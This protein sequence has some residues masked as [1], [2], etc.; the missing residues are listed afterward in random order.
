MVDPANPSATPAVVEAG[1]T[2]GERG[3]FSGTIDANQQLTNWHTRTIIYAKGDGRLY[4]ISTLRDNSQ[5]PSQ[6]SSEAGASI[7]CDTDWRVDFSDHNQSVYL[8][9][10]AGND[11]NCLLAGDNIWKM[12]RVGMSAT[13]SPI[14]AKKVVGGIWDTNSAIIGF[15]VIEGQ[16][17]V[18]CDKNFQNCS[19]VISFANEGKRLWGSLL[20]VD[21][22]IYHYNVN[23]SSL[24]SPLHT[25]SVG[26]PT[27]VPRASDGFNLYFADGVKL[28]S[29]PLNGSK[30]STLLVTENGSI[31]TIALTTN[32]ATYIVSGSIK[33]IGKLGGG[34]ATV[35]VQN[36]AIQLTATGNH[37]Y[38][39]RLSPTV[40]S[41]GVIND[42]GAG[43]TE[44]IGSF[45]N[46]STLSSTE[47]A[48][49]FA[50]K[51]LI[52]AEGCSVNS[53]K[54][55]TLKSFDAATNSGETI[56]GTTPDDVNNIFLFGFEDQILGVGNDVG[57]NADV[58]FADVTQ[59]NSLKRIT[60][61]S[62]IDEALI[63]T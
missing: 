40:V 44:L 29:L 14:T 61:T 5:T 42:D 17:I 36:D 57:D 56:L 58:F 4:K 11:G 2:T 60:K 21:N 15:L 12:V 18:R 55:A 63:G 28:L 45:W 47:T 22:K 24:S 3:I 52:R 23:T 10:L 48:S 54:G 43:G 9:E 39:N 27:S 7:L 34:P 50:L 37:V 6:I 31:N 30:L 49:G 35:L 46:G 32:S 33:A 26:T 51:R 16:E 8:Y 13:D 19:P 62:T 41:S 38:Y 20:Q 59:P 1:A 53:C 25:F